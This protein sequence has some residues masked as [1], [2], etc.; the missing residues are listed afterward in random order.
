MYGTLTLRRINVL[1]CSGKNGFGDSRSKLGLK[2]NTFCRRSCKNVSP[3]KKCFAQIVYKHL[4]SVALFF[5]VSRQNVQTLTAFVRT[6]CSAFRSFLA[7]I[8][9]RNSQA[10]FGSEVALPRHSASWKLLFVALFVHSLKA[11]GF[12]AT[13]LCDIAL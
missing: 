10:T 5:F 7:S 3:M 6:F 8:V 9:L 2:A 11:Q 13:P 12:A 1:G 4:T